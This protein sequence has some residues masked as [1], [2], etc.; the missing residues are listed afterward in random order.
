MIDLPRS[1]QRCWSR[2]L[3]GVSLSLALCS[4]PAHAAWNVDQLMQALAQNKSGH[5]TFVEKKYIAMLE[6]PLESSGDLL[7]SAPDRLEKRTL[8]PK[9][10]SMVLQGNTLTIER[11]RRQYVLA[12]QDYPELGAF[13]ES[14]R[15]TL[16]GDQ[17]ALARIYNMALEGTE[18]RWTLTLQPIEPKMAAAVRRVVIH[19][20]RGELHSIEIEQADKD[21]SVMTITPV[22]LP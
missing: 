6:R 20:S 18:E 11:G 21:R 3:A 10:E 5:A 9:P 16:A 13:T 1:G 7:Y 14:I 17:K 15:G 2:L 12:L 8:K 22:T 4:V 19:G